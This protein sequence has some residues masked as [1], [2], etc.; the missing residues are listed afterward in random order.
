MLTMARVPLVIPAIVAVL[1]L[2]GGIVLVMTLAVPP[3]YADLGPASLRPV[4]LGVD[5]PLARDVGGYVALAAVVGILA[6]STA[7]IVRLRRASKSAE[8]V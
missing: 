3:D 5:L 2:V 8:P 7:A 6:G 1:A 4:D